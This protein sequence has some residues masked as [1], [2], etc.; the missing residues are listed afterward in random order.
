[1]IS[2]RYFSSLVLAAALIMSR[3][4]AIDIPDGTAPSSSS[5]SDLT[6]DVNFPN[7]IPAIDL[8]YYKA[9]IVPIGNA[10]V[11]GT[12]YVKADPFHSGSIV[13]GGHLEGLQSGLMADNCTA[14]NG[15]GVHIHSGYS[16]NSTATQLGH[17]FN[18]QTVLTDPW[19]NQ[20]YSSN[21]DGVANF[22]SKVELGTTDVNGR[23]FIVHS[24]SGARVACGLLQ[25][26]KVPIDDEVKPPFAVCQDVASSACQDSNGAP[27]ILLSKKLNRQYRSKQCKQECITASSQKDPSLLLQRGWSC[28]PCPSQT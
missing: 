26:Q 18:N 13:Y 2:S 6:T 5:L 27:G 24:S 20:R 19:M 22:V 21:R 11:R 23:A 15:C 25:E 28:G 7:S 4:S 16:C 12:V 17:F 14:T 3:A 10:T 8:K 1:M 9:D